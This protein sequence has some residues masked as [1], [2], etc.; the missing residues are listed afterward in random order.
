MLCQMSSRSAP[1]TVEKTTETKP[2][3]TEETNKILPKPSRY[4]EYTG[5]GIKMFLYIFLGN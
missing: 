1:M 4:I 5:M 2:A 3:S